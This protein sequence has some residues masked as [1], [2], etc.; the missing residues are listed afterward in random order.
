MSKTYRRKK[1]VWSFDNTDFK[2]ENNIFI[3]YYLDKNSKEYAKKIAHF[4]SDSHYGWCVPHWY[5][6]MFFERKYRRDSKNKIHKW[7]KN[8]ENKE[9]I[10]DKY[11]KS[12]GY[13]YF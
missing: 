13:D 3:R 6:N 1:D 12:A 11:F 5:V 2:Y 10:I 9:I 7:M 8:P 4:H